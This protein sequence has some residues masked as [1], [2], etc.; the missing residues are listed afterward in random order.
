MSCWLPITKLRRLACMSSRFGA[1][2]EKKSADVILSCLKTGSDPRSMRGCV[3]GAVDQEKDGS[4]ARRMARLCFLV[5]RMIG[6]AGKMR[7]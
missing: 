2:L 4:A 3:G 5:V 7:A 1:P 6:K